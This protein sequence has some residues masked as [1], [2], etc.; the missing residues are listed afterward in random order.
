M[1]IEIMNRLTCGFVGIFIVLVIITLYCAC[2]ISGRN[3][4]E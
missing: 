1:T 3:R 4:D 2:V